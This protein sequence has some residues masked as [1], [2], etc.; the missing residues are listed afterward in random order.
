[1]SRGVGRRLPD[2]DAGLT[3]LETLIVLAVIAVVTGATVLSLSPR[4]DSATEAEARRLATTIQAAV[5]RS[6]ATGS[7]D[8]L[9]VD[10]TGY[11]LAGVRHALPAGTAVTGLPPAG[12]SLGFATGHPFTLVVAAGGDRWMVAF[13]GLRAAAVRGAGTS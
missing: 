5:D 9:V 13:D 7:H 2:R 8:L 12:V 1:L 6:I 10:D 11:A 4:R 3:L